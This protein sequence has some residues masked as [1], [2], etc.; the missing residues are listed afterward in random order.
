MP[1]ALAILGGLAL[2]E[3]VKVLRRPG[4]RVSTAPRGRHQIGWRDAA[5]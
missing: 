1:I 2:A 3:A 5:R 4:W